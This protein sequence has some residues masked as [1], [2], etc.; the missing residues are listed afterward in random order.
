MIYWIEENGKIADLNLSLSDIG[1]DKTDR[2]WTDMISEL[3]IT[4]GA[5]DWQI[6]T[7]AIK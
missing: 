4:T 6:D 3:S 2:L 5:V 7:V 1:L